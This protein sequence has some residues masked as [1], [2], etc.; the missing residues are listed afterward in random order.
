M[1][2][3]TSVY[4]YINIYLV[5]GDWNMSFMTFHILGTIVPFDELHDFSEG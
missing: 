5:G 2:Y 3:S 4:D 1:V